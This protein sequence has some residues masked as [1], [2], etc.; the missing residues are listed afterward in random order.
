M[1]EKLFNGFVSLAEKTWNQKVSHDRVIVDNYYENLCTF[2]LFC[3][4]EN[5]MKKNIHDIF[6]LE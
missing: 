1:K 5:E 4:K 3:Q 6:K 2:G